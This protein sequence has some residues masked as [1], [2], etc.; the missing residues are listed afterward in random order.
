MAEGRQD[1]REDE[2]G[3]MLGTWHTG[4]G[5]RKESPGQEW[6]W[7]GLGPNYEKHGN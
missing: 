7:V 1:V 2:E 5:G 4:V 6:G 3:S